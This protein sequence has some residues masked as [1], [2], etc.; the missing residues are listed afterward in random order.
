MGS[1]NDADKAS[2][3][4]RPTTMIMNIINTQNWKRE[5]NPHDTVY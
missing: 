3:T 1:Y 5:A 2:T 4:Y